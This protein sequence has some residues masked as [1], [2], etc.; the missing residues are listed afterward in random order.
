MPHYPAAAF[1][2]LAIAAQRRAALANLNRKALKRDACSVGPAHIRA[3]LMF[4]GR[5]FA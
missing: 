1:A 5:R 3:A 4:A 2:I